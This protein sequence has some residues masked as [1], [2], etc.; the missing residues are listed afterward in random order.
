MAQLWGGRFTKET[1]QAVFDFNASI[2]FDKKMFEQ[3]ITGSIAH[4]VMRVALLACRIDRVSAAVASQQSCEYVIEACVTFVLSAAECLLRV[5]PQFFAYQRRV[6][7]LVDDP[8]L[9]FPILRVIL[10]A[11]CGV[12]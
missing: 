3:D 6:R 7:S 5:L 8:P 1:E 4:V 11:R 12:I 9:D 10:H 2:R